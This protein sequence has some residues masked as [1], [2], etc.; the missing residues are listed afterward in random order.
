MKIRRRT[1][2]GLVAA[3]LVPGLVACG[4]KDGGSGKSDSPADPKEAL[5]ASTE[6]INEGNFRFTITDHE[7]SGEG[8]VHL[9]SRSAQMLLK[10]TSED[11]TMEMDVIQVD[12]DTWVKLKLDLGELEGLPGFEH[13]SGD[14]YMHL[15]RSKVK[16]N[17]DLQF[18]DFDD[19]DPAS[20][21]L[22]IEAIT[23]VKQAGEGTY[24]GTL[25]LSKAT[26]A[27]VVSEEIITALGDQAKALEFEAKLDAEGRLTEFTI[28]VPAAGEVEA[29]EVKVTYFDY[30]SASA[31][32]KPAA[33]EVIEAPAEVYEMLK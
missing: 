18:F 28:K 13:F 5:I 11:V 19:V 6:A 10:F 25:D 20:S 3:L 24:S 7:S 9:P 32:Q 21:K 33:S 4:S 17:K 15:D 23:D 14:K 2:A 22:L 31:P 29:H 26:D 27:G 1:I 16:E 12:P 30:G 8:M